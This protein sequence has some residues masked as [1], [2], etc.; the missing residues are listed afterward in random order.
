[1]NSVASIDE[2]S[3]QAFKLKTVAPFDALLEATHEML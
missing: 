1:M 3:H 2:N